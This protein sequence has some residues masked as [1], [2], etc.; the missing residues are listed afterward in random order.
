M[1]EKTGWL[2]LV[3]VATASAPPD[4]PLSR[5]E[6]WQLLFVVIAATLTSISN[7]ASKQADGEAFHALRFF[8]NVGICTMAGI[9]T[10]LFTGWVLKTDAN[11]Q[12]SIGLSIVG[13]Y[14]GRDVLTWLYSLVT[15]RGDEK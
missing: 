7:E 6:G 4:F 12:A 10:P 1:I 11:W 14:F 2:G 13:A 8:G 9:A 15:K 3:L 5:S